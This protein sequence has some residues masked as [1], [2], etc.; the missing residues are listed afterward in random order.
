MEGVWDGSMFKTTFD[1]DS[2]LWSLNPGCTAGMRTL[3]DGSV[4]CAGESELFL[5]DK[6]DASSL[7]I[8]GGLSYPNGLEV[9]LDDFVYVTEQNAGT[10]RRVNPFTGDYTVL[11]TGLDNP[12]GLSF[13]P[14]YDLLYVGSFGSGTIYTIEVNEDGEPG[15]VVTFVEKLGTGLLD[16]LGVDICGNLYV[17]DWVAVTLYRIS[18][19]GTTID[20][21]ENFWTDSGWIPNMQWGSGYGGWNEFHLFV[22]DIEDRVYELPIGVPSKI[23]N[24]P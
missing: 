19:D 4:V 16:G 7:M 20:Q 1:G 13:N 14:D 6:T 15:E 12:N 3:S 8:V 18:P 21:I 24:Y 23:R 2:K 11:A 17:C 22:I 5:I 10:V 9:D